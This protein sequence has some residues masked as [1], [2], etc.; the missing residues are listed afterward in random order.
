MDLKN[1]PFHAEQSWTVTNRL[2]EL[3]RIQRIQKRRVVSFVRWFQ[4][5]KRSWLGGFKSLSLAAV[6]IQVHS[7]HDFTQ[8]AETHEKQ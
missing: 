1:Q 8:K 5:C 4:I 6:I 2:Y 3:P 7:A